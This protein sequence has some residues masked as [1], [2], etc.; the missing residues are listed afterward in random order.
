MSILESAAVPVLAAAAVAVLLVGH[1]G[2]WRYSRTAVT[3]AHEGGHALVAVLTG[4]RLSGIRLHSDTS[5]VTVS[6]GRPSG[7]GMVCTA[8]A[9]YLAPSVVGVAA[10]GAVAADQSPALLWAVVALLLVTLLYVRN[11]FGGA[12]ILLSGALVGLVAW[13]GG[14]QL[15]PAF[16]AVLAWFLLLGGL[17]AVYELA[18]GR[19]RQ[20]R[21]DPYRL[22]SDA[23]QLGR[24]TGLPAGLWIGVFVLVAFASLLLGGWLLLGA[25]RPDDL[26]AALT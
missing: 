25:P 24:L 21:R 1:R 12:A 15:R 14:P 11:L 19:R 16:G 4:R 17:R 3:I 8:L 6:V 2:V 5:G 13:Y 23:D 9:G 18:G 20:A 7:P 26:L 10:A 22:D